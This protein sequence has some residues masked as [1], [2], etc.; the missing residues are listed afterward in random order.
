MALKV[1]KLLRVKADTLHHQVGC[2]CLQ[3]HVP[4]RQLFRY[5]YARYVPLPISM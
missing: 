3:H 5:I 2:Y 4:N 1:R